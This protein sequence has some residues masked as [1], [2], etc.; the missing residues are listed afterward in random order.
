MTV[1]P[2]V[3]LTVRPTR[4]ASL[5]SRR[6]RCQSGQCLQAVARGLTDL[7]EAERLRATEEHRAGIEQGEPLVRRIHDRRAPNRRDGIEGV[8]RF[9]RNHAF[10]PW[11][12]RARFEHLQGEG[13]GDRALREQT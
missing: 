2:T 4:G 10:H 5:L 12:P 1:S 7:A 9:E 6:S 3:S 13:A 11:R 8:R